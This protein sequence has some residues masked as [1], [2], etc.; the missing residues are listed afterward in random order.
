MRLRAGLADALVAATAKS[1]IL[2]NI[3][4]GEYDARKETWVYCGCSVDNCGY[5]MRT[6]LYRCAGVATWRTILRTVERRMV[7]LGLVH[8]DRSESDIRHHGY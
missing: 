5:G 4:K 6:K 8:T 7:A 3:D 2:S 1:D